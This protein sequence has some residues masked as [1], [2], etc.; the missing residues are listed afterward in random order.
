[1]GRELAPI[2]VVIVV[3]IVVDNDYD[4]DYMRS[5]TLDTPV[6]SRSDA[7]RAPCYYPSESSLP[8]KILSTDYADFT[9]LEWVTMHLFSSSQSV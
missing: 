6:L 3:V 7:P 8:E 2:L 5:P 1:L 4:D 9:D